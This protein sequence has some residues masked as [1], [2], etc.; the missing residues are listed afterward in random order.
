MLMVP[1]HLSCTTDAYQHRVEKVSLYFVDGEFRS[2]NSNST[3]TATSAIDMVL[4]LVSPPLLLLLLLL[5]G[6]V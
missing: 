2:L 5:Q 4:L 6:K 3:A 1:Q